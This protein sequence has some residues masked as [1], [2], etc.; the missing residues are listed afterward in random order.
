[1]VSHK[2]KFI[3]VHICR[4]GSKSVEGTLKKYCEE[5]ISH[6]TFSKERSPDWTGIDRSKYFKFAYVRNPWDRLV[7]LYEW[8]RQIATH[9]LYNKLT[10]N[11][12]F[13][14][15]I[16]FVEMHVYYKVHMMPMYDRLKD[17]E[18]KLNLDFI[19]RFE[20]INEDWKVIQNRI[21]VTDPLPHTNKS[22]HR[23][24]R[25]YYNKWT[26]EKVRQIYKKDIEAFGYNF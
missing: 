13:P 10:H 8:G 7:S 3:F 22:K 6:Q 2:K 15:F 16:K 20:R 17:E 12:P 25:D 11:V 9:N 18:G 19:G 26:K 23:N 5:F 4:A 21:G 1:M 14:L 24:Y